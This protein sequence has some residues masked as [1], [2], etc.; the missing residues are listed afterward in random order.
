MRTTGLGGDS[1][2]SWVKSGFNI[3][4]RRVT[5]LVLAGN[6]DPTGINQALSRFSQSPAASLKQELFMAMKEAQFRFQPTT[7]ESQIVKLLQNH[8]H[9]PEELASALGIISPKFLPTERLEEGGVIQRCRADPNR[10]SAYS[11]RLQ[12]MGSG[13][14]APDAGN[15]LRTLQKNNIRP[16]R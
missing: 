6:V 10:S 3:G 15:S 13:T 1:L 12:K 5:P 2:I 14:C 16:G 4:P 11:R 7:T 9:A 8:P